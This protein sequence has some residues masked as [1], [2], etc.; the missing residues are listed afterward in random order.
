M[1]KRISIFYFYFEYVQ[2]ILERNTIVAEK[3]YKKVKYSVRRQVDFIIEVPKII[4][5]EEN[6]KIGG[7][8]LHSRE[9]PRI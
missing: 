3:V 6:E 7:D 4:F 5:W 2:Y 1:K 9:M 8:N